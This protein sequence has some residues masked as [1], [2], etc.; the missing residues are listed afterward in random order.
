MNGRDVAPAIPPMPSTVITELAPF[1]LQ[2]RSGIG[3]GYRSRARIQTH[4]DVCS[5]RRLLFFVA[6]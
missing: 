2:Q 6:L 3:D 1:R 5:V 4:G